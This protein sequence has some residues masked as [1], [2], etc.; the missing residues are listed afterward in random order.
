MRFSF[1]CML[2]RYTI[3]S[4]FSNCISFYANSGLRPSRT[5]ADPGEIYLFSFLSFIERARRRRI[6]SK[7]CTLYCYN[8]NN[9]I[10]VLLSVRYCTPLQQYNAWCAR[11]SNI[12][13]KSFRRY[14]KQWLSGRLKLNPSE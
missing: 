13:D 5:A 6:N 2:R 9:N 11:R 8:N 3:I 4:L 12:K 10:R 1:F 7:S 14:T